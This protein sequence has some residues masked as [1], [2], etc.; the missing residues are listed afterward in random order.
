MV[1]R[2]R[3]LFEVFESSRDNGKFYKLSDDM[4][5][6]QA[7]QEL[8][9]TE[10]GLYLEF[11]VKYTKHKDGTDNRNNITM[12]NSEYSKLLNERTYWK[13]IDRLID[14]GFMKVIENRWNTRESTIYGFNDQWKYYGTPEFSVTDRDRRAKRNYSEEHISKVKAALEVTNARKIKQRM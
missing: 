11:K 13:A 7:W 5:Q 10:R 12:P 1:K 4:V 8:S 2:K 6:S 9:L 3:R 14:L